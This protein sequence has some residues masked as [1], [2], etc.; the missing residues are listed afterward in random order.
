MA[1][2]NDLRQLLRKEF[3]GAHI[4]L[5]MYKP[6]KRLGGRLVWEGF[7]GQMQIDRQVRLHEVVQALPL[8]ERAKVS[9][10]LTL[11][12]EEESGMLVP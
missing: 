3:P 8:R 6:D 12:P 9:L 1:L 11:T 10:I 4:K 7:D 5:Q 2:I